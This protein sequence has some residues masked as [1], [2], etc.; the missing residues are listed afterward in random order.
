LI[1]VSGEAGSG[2]TNFCLF[3]AINYII[4]NYLN[5]MYPRVLYITISK[6]FPETRAKQIIE[7]QL[8]ATKLDPKKIF[9]QLKLFHSNDNKEFDYFVNN[10]Q[11]YIRENKI[12]MVVIDSFT[13]L[14]DFEFVNEGGEVD[15]IA[16]KEF[17]T[18]KLKTLK[19][20]ISDFNL[21]MILVNNVSSTFND[22]NKG[23]L[24]NNNFVVPNL[25]YVFENKINTRILLKKDVNKRFIEI[26]FSNYLDENRA[27]FII[28]NSGL[29]IVS[30]N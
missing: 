1:E 13:A 14:A 17:V 5:K 19:K 22:I 8:K 9:S 16:R 28:E 12:G 25:G 21:F 29:K 18:N 4:S 27:E 24:N 11:S 2:K 20:L 30:F 23:V 6:G 26:A 7:N 15:Y 3:V 10:I